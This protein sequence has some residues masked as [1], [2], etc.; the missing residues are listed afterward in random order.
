MIRALMPSL[1]LVAALPV[2]GRD[3][4]QIPLEA[5]DWRPR[6]E[7]L[8]DPFLRA[9]DHSLAFK[10][11]VATF[12]VSSP[13]KC[14]IWTCDLPKP[15]D[16]GRLRF[17]TLRY[18][19]RGL[20]MIRGNTYFL[21]LGGTS[22]GRG[23]GGSE[24]IKL[25]DLVVNGQWQTHTVQLTR[26]VKVR[27][28]AVHIM[29]DDRPAAVE[30]SL[31]ELTRRLP[32]PPLA[33]S[34]SFT[35]GWAEGVGAFKPSDLEGRMGVRLGL[36]KQWKVVTDWF[37]SAQVT[38]HRVPFGVRVKEHLAWEARPGNTNGIPVW[39][40]ASEM[41]FLMG[42]WLAGVRTTP[43]HRVGTFDRAIHRDYRFWINVRYA[44]GATDRHFPYCLDTDRY[45]TA[46]GVKAYAIPLDPKK[47]L[48]DVYFQA[49]MR[50]AH[51]AV[52]AITLNRSP[53]PRRARL[54]QI[55]R[56]PEPAPVPKIKA[57]RP[58]ITYNAGRL[59]V[60]GGCYVAEFA[61]E[62]GF[63]LASLASGWIGDALK[64]APGAIF[65]G[66]IGLSFFRSTDF[67]LASAPD[68]AAKGR[69]VVLR[70]RPTR[71]DIPFEA[72]LTLRADD[73]RE[74]WMQ[75]ALRN[76]GK[77]AVTPRFIFPNIPGVT[78]G[79]LRDTWYLCPQRG[80][81]L[82]NR[83]YFGGELRGS[84]FPLQFLDAFNPRLNGGLA[85]VTREKTWA[86]R[87][88]RL[89]K[90]SRGVAMSIEHRIG[91]RLAPG[92]DRVLPA[93]VLRFHPGDWHEPY[94]NYRAWAQQA[95]KP[96][97]PR[98]E[99]FRKRFNFH[100]FRCHDKPGRRTAMF[101]DKAMKW[102]VDHALARRTAWHGK[103]EYAHLFDWRI[104]PKGGKWGTYHDYD[105]VGGLPA[106]KTA[107][108]KLQSQGMRVG[109]YL[110]GFLVS[111]RS[112]VAKEHPEWRMRLHNGRYDSNHSTPDET[113]YAMCP[114][115][116]AWQD[117]MANTIA[118]L[119]RD[120][121]VD[122]IY[123]DEFGSNTSGY[124]CHSK[125]HGHDT[126]MPPM[127]GEIELMAKVRRALPDRVA[128]YVEAGSADAEI[129]VIDG[130]FGY[131]SGFS[132]PAVSPGGV[133]LQRFVFPTYKL[134]EI[135]PSP[136][137]WNAFKDRLY[138]ILFNGL[139][140]NVSTYWQEH[141]L[142]LKQRRM[143]QL[144]Q[145]HADAF[146]SLRARPLIPTLTEGIYA[147]EFPGESE[148]IWTVL[149]TH[150][151]TV[152]CPVLRVE[153][154]PGATYEDLWNRRTLTPKIV[155]GTAE[156]ALELDC[157]GVACVREQKPNE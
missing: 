113:I 148:T 122:G 32:V 38:A 124:W 60:Q 28:V 138:C 64:A 14:M 45:E 141:D 72:A 53:E 18:R 41:Y 107:I 132:D 12:E 108:Q 40:K 19:A 98:P 147:N 97:C 135:N 140:L 26:Q 79:E 121:G 77:Q 87:I 112:P 80:A 114:H 110:E 106:F 24:Q 157:R 94:E 129:A 58:T 93:A 115:V 25:K 6:A 95:F 146:C 111:A 78:V 47:T 74:L 8:G 7:W 89:G 56:V 104:S 100:T 11:G 136:R 70:L 125:D 123:L 65:T 35:N 116:P 143:M 83:N 144:M 103:P 37:T 142:L 20:N 133:P 62:P 134:F 49:D 36:L 109:L 52:A 5:K 96:P 88:W 84:Y 22:G 48:R 4:A 17:V 50:H 91:M 131:T 75:L 117:W 156:I 101:D 2:W 16:T 30:L 126:P 61:M 102:R 54:W 92:A 9:R 99:W 139:G 31:A 21:Y 151:R 1:L 119:V 128:L 66:R 46:R 10:D 120:T 3:A 155:G 85:L 33:E 57:G 152:R 59:T 27:E 154:V 118:K 55:R 137:N 67:Q 90:D 23:P 13:R 76:V 145:Q 82:S 43:H 69:Q 81:M 153:H 73:P 15:I 42:C 39:G 44:D 86:D 71:N 63:R 149:N 34:L 29:A 150:W 130:A 127:R 51:F 68:I 105:A